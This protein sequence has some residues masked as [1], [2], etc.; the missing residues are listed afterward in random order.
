[1]NWWYLIPIICGVIML[2]VDPATLATM[3]A[4]VPLIVIVALAFEWLLG[5]RPPKRK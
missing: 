5:P 1:M 3:L 4:G 2:F